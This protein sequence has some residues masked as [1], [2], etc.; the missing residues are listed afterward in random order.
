MDLGDR[1]AEFRFLVRDRAGQFTQSFD[2][3]LASA[4]IQTMKIP[5]RSPRA[6]PRAAYCTSY[7]R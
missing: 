5:P 3:A 1:A 2:A 4:G 6:K 7:G